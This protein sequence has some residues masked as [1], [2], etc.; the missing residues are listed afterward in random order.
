MDQAYSTAPGPA[1][2]H[3]IHKVTGNKHLT[4]VHMHQHYKH[5]GMSNVHQKT[6]TNH[7]VR[8]MIHSYYKHTQSVK[9]LIVSTEMHTIST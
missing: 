1:Q 7:G 3:I 8:L 5:K 2:S 4:Q 6:K 9:F